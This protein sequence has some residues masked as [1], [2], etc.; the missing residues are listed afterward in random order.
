MATDSR[1]D[2]ASERT[3]PYCTSLRAIGCAALIFALLGGAGA[4][5]LPFGYEQLQAGK[6]PLGIALMVVGLFTLPLLFFSFSTLYSGIRDRIRPPLV[7]VTPTALM[8][9]PA[10]RAGRPEQEKQEERDEPKS[11][12]SPTHP[13]AIPFAA[14]R[15][16]YRESKVNPGSDRLVIVHDLAPMPLVL[17][18]YMMHPTDFDD[19]ERVLRRSLM[20]VAK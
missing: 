6:M 11:R 12:D 13:E 9:P 18:Q 5:M 14:I 2:P 15:A 17:E 3:Y 4:A 19:L 16:L 20:S 1:L 10:P 7:R 8:L